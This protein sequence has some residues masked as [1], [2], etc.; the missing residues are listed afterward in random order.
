MKKRKL[1]FFSLTGMVLCGVGMTVTSLVAL[2]SEKESSKDTFVAYGLDIADEDSQYLGYGYDVTSGKAISDPNALN[3]AN[4]ILDVNNP[5][6][7]AYEKAFS[8]SQTTYLSYSSK[9]SQEMAEQ[10]GM[11]LGGGV[12]GKIQVVT[13]SIDTKFNTQSSFSKKAEEEYSYFSIY[14]KNRTIVIQAGIDELVNFLSPN[15]LKDARNIVSENDANNFLNKYGTHLVTGYNLGGIFE[16]TNY[17]ATSSS[18][19]I[20]QNDISFS[21]QV[22]V[23][24]SNYGAGVNFSFSENYG[25][26]DNNAFA[27]NNYKCTTY[28]GYTFPGLTIDQAFSFYQT[29][30]GAGYIYG[31]WTDSINAGKNLSIV[32]IPESSKLIPLYNL[33]PDS[34]DYND[35]REKL[36]E[37]YI[38]RCGLTYAQFLEKYPEINS[39]VRPT[40][41]SPLEIGYTG[42]GYTEYK[43]VGT[44][45]FTSVYVPSDEYQNSITVNRG[46]YL[47]FD[48][49]QNLYLGRDVEWKVLKPDN[50]PDPGNID[51]KDDRNGVFQITP[52]CEIGDY[53]I[54]LEVDDVEVYG[55]FIKVEDVRYF[56]GSGSSSNPYQISS[57]NDLITL[58]NNSSDWGKSFRLIND[59]VVSDE[60]VS[61]L[62]PIG[63]ETTPFTGEFDGN[64]HSICKYRLY[65]NTSA[66]S[67][68]TEHLGL[69][70]YNRGTISNLT[71]DADR[72]ADNYDDGRNIVTNFK[73]DNYT[74]FLN[75]GNVLASAISADKEVVDTSSVSGAL[76][77]FSPAANPSNF[78]SNVKNV[79]GIVGYNAG[80]VTN[81]T[82]NNLDVRVARYVSTAIT[83]ASATN[84][85]RTAVGGICGY[86][87]NI[88]V[89]NNCYSNECSIRANVYSEEDNF[90]E[91]DIGGIIGYN[92]S[93]FKVSHCGV[94]K[95]GAQGYV[96][97]RTTDNLRTKSCFIGGIIGRSVK[98]IS[99]CSVTN[100]D[101]LTNGSTADQN[102]HYLVAYLRG[103]AANSNIRV[104][105]FIGGVTLS[106][107][108]TIENCV[109][110]KM[111]ELYLFNI[112]K[113]S[114]NLKLLRYFNSVYHYANAM[115]AKV[116][117]STASFN[118]CYLKL[119]TASTSKMNYAL[120]SK[121]VSGVNVGE[122]S[123]NSLVNSSSYIATGGDW[124]QGS[125]GYPQLVVDKII[126]GDTSFD[127]SKAKRVF[128]YTET[129]I[130]EFSTGEIVVTTQTTTGD[131][132]KIK[133]FNI[134]TTEFKNMK[135][136]KKRGTCNIS[137]SANGKTAKYQVKIVDPSY[138]GIECEE[139]SAVSVDYYAG[140]LFNNKGLLVH[141]ITEVGVDTTVE[142]KYKDD[143]TPAQLANREYYEIENLDAPLR[144]GFNNF[145]VK[146]FD[147][148]TNKELSTIYTV[149]AKAST[150][151]SLTKTANPTSANIPVGTT[152][153]RPIDLEGL[154]IDV[155]LEVV[156]D[157]DAK[158]TTDDEHPHSYSLVFDKN[159]LKRNKILVDYAGANL[160]DREIDAD[161]VE[162]ISPTIKYGNENTVKVCYQGYNAST[163][164][165]V[166]GTYDSQ[167]DK[168]A[169]LNDILAR[170]DKDG[171]PLESVNESGYLVDESDILIL[172]RNGNPLLPIKTLEE[173]FNVIQEAIPLKDDL[174]S[175]SGDSKYVKACQ[176]LEQVINQYN[177]DV[178]GINE[179]VLYSVRVSSS[180][181]YHDLINSGLLAF[182]LIFALLLIAL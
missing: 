9:S 40:N 42:Y 34:S 86:N 48:F 60:Q 125:N 31:L 140:D 57:V 4:P 130:E 17:Y 85:G 175:L 180:F 54:Y 47:S 179:A 30:F 149:Y 147:V 70:G 115:T 66:I 19:Y 79:G 12:S 18:S 151:R 32:S 41:L 76:Y 82:V 112:E 56:G 52:L 120:D 45:E 97:D 146:Y 138:I 68:S 16:M 96:S 164:F 43:E 27:V 156:N 62:K 53:Y 171:K 178:R 117:G 77:R 87:S 122:F 165:T 80:T 55:I 124:E 38:K 168:L 128:Y 93:P 148:N 61:S 108:D 73:K 15:Y 37:S 39:T 72:S 119:D 107:N 1:K 141:P 155:T 14:A 6:L 174:V 20:R 35:A 113:T 150:V 158:E 71:L 67:A 25:S 162:I 137:V 29:A 166:N 143:A 46:N 5:N 51:V 135:A 123:W 160:R 173:R 91:L 98:G 44:N 182:T 116:N 172:D 139:D 8:A 159:S 33:L 78:L 81:C 110:Y 111:D 69:F 163:E 104:G 118:E 89:I 3:L 131:T 90:D 2:N 157:A 169:E 103:S 13:V 59:I 114:T 63:N 84:P 161:E 100:I 95:L 153:I 136:Q 92:E 121:S 23:A 181:F 154:K 7:I 49:N 133:N 142:L 64:Y 106:S 36:L 129:G 50:T 22:N 83:G 74:S 26:L 10:Y 126:Y 167:G 21:S 11:T 24:L 109:G 94:D 132:V 170:F 58:M 144:K 176:K 105:G 99:N 177:N 101:G 145:K 152:V 102:K 134:D 75:K 88:G 127:F 65:Y 28:G